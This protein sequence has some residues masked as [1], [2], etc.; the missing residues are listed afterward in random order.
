VARL[1]PSEVFAHYHFAAKLMAESELFAGKHEVAKGVEKVVRLDTVVKTE[2]IGARLSLGATCAPGGV[3]RWRRAPGGR[4]FLG[5]LHDLTSSYTN[6]SDSTAARNSTMRA[7]R[8]ASSHDS[9][10]SSASVASGAT[11]DS[12]A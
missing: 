4:V 6:P 10:L 3:T 5:T 2:F 7:G 9:S 12:R 11:A 1:A 8:R